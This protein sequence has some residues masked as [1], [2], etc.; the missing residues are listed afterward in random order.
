MKIIKVLFITSVVIV[1]CVG[2]GCSVE[3]DKK[4]SDCFTAF[5]TLLSRQL[6]R[7]TTF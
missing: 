7:I 5:R 4:Q 2:R 3:L 6:K 1:K